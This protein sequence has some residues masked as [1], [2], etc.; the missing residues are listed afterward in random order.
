MSDFTYFIIISDT[1][2][3]LKTLENIIRKLS[4]NA[5]ILKYKDGEE[6]L[7][8]IAKQKQ[9]AVIIL[10]KNL[11]KINGLQLIG[12]LHKVE[13]LPNHHIILLTEYEDQKLNLEALKIGANE[14]LSEP[15]SIDKLIFK[16]RNAYRMVVSS[17]S[18]IGLKSTT[19]KLEQQIQNISNQTVKMLS[20]IQKELFGKQDNLK[21]IYDS[22]VWI[23][24]QL[25]NEEEDK[26]NIEK[27]A[28]IAYIGKIYLPEKLITKPVL[29]DGRLQNDK[30]E[31]VPHFVK[32]L[33]GDIEPLNG[34]FK[35]LYH[36]YENFDGSGIPEKE[37]AWKIPIGSRILRVCID[38][39]D[40]YERTGKKSSKAI[41]SLLHESKRLYDHRV[42][43]YYDQ[44]LAANTKYNDARKNEMM[45]TTKE[46]TEGMILSRN[47]ITDGGLKLM[48]EGQD[49][50]EAKIQKI[51]TISATDP[52][53][54]NIYIQR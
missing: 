30:M 2:T 9:P 11:A 18:E 3:T 21:Q 49:L 50:T 44:F 26:T 1:D 53:I 20:V 33:I 14:V 10:E 35:I 8:G 39:L 31:R 48:P 12:K 7:K 17:N 19:S 38:Y 27:A 36:I 37:K 16:I 45:V 42:I 24:Q 5:V 47:I 54:G 4:S 22:A 46:L 6:G 40:I 32:H 13:E 23:S 43:A 34:V 51:L 52:I 29:I 15:F 25:C 41:E 28:Q